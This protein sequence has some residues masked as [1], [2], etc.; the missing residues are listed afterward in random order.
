MSATQGA[1]SL[2]DW[3]VGRYEDTAARLEPVARG[4]VERAAPVAG[5]HVLDVGCG[6]GNAALLAAARGA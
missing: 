2:F 3:G 4:V 1:A 5:E 6:T